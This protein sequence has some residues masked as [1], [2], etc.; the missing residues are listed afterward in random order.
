MLRV[1]EDKSESTVAVRVSGEIDARTGPTLER[2]VL[3]AVKAGP[4]R[5]VVDLRDVGFMDSAGVTVLVRA[6]KRLKSAGREPLV[7]LASKPVHRL[8]ELTGIDTLVDVAGTGDDCQRDI[9]T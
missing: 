5:T 2:A 6:A 3:D 8:L 9:P 4:A 1:W 7:V